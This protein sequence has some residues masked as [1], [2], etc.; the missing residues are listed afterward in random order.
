MHLH[1][2]PA[3]VIGYPCHLG[4]SPCIVDGTV[5]SRDSDIAEEVAGKEA[6][7]LQTGANELSQTGLVAF[8]E[9][10]IVVEHSSGLRMFKTQEQSEQG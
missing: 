6:T 5:G 3:Y 8:R 1:G 2:H 10:V 4:G 7:P 9:V